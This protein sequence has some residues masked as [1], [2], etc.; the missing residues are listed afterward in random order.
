MAALSIVHFSLK[1]SFKKLWYTNVFIYRKLIT[2]SGNVRKVKKNY[3]F[4]LLCAAE[5]GDERSDVGVSQP[6]VH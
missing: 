1:N 4:S 5:R 3:C 6:A 2:L